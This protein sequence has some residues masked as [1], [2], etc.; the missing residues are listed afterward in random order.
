MK[1]LR[2]NLKKEGSMRSRRILLANL[3]TLPNQLTLVRLVSV[4]IIWILALRGL[5]VGV[6]FGLSLALFTDFIDGPLARRL[7]QTSDFGAKFDSLADQLIQLSAILWVFILMPEII[8][9]NLPASILA[10][11]VYLSSLAVGML[12]FKRIANLHLHFSKASGFLLY[13]F[14]IHA[15]W[16]G[17]YSPALFLLACTAFVVSSAE[18]L[19]LQL[20]SSEVDENIG[21][22][23][24]LYL[25][26]DHLLRRL[27][28]KLP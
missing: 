4:P 23:L 27:A 14:L 19:L 26:A 11:G 20:I 16:S 22:V 3:R 2:T 17:Q 5:R 28:R 8:T 18:T 13:T 24:F 15:F 25:P 21:S 9:D 10:I 1:R 12:K 6:G 7:D